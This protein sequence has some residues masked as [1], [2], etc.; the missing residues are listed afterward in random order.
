MRGVKGLVSIFVPFLNSECFLAEAIE[1]VLNQTYSHWELLLVDDGSTDRSTEIALDY[2]AKMPEKIRYCEHPGHRNCGLTS[3]RNL[4]ARNSRGEYLAFL[5]SDDLWF[6]DKLKEQVVLMDSHPQAAMIYGLS[7]FWYDFRAGESTPENHIP[8]IAPGDR[9]YAPSFLLSASYPLGSFGVPC[10]SSYMV[11]REAFESVGGCVERFNPSTYQLF[12]DMAF[13][14]KIYLR[15]PVYV[16]GTCWGRYRCHGS[17]MSETVETAGSYRAERRFYF[18][19]L[20]GY[21]MQKS[22]WDPR[23][24]IAVL[25]Q[26]WRDWMPLPQWAIR[27]HDRIRHGS[28]ASVLSP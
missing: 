9:M 16:S 25:R 27:L 20:R 10:P 21:L 13:L 3:S 17:S 1:S 15:F 4:A 26:T 2:A 11:R 23:I 14:A 6:P 8:P 28:N 19:W 18:A 7:E 22:I 12:E 5:D 24:W